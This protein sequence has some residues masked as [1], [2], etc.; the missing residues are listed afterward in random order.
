M[1]GDG[2]AEGT[3][4]G[5][6]D[7]GGRNGMSIAPGPAVVEFVRAGGDRRQRGQ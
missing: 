1:E 4:T 6:D 5:P 3:G 2:D 7:G